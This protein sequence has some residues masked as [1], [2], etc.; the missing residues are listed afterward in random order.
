MG[1][2]I[3]DGPG[4]IGGGIGCGSGII[5]GY[6]GIYV[7]GPG[8]IS[9]LSSI[10]FL[11]LSFSFLIWSNFFLSSLILSAKFYVYWSTSFIAFS[12]FMIS[13]KMGSTIGG[14]GGG[15][16]LG[17]GP[18]GSGPGGKSS[19]S[20]SFAFFIFFYLSSLFCA[21]LS[22][23]TFLD[24]AVKSDVPLYSLYIWSMKGADLFIRSII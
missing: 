1:S 19:M 7:P 9:L 3:L 4:C 20:S 17:S 6:G 21:L 23:L 22:L 10:Y 12:N 5:I 16:G 24:A 8:G 18:G 2:C 13:S 11:R 14:D 15:S